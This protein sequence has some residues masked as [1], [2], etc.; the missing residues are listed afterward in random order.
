MSE[1]I[2]SPESAEVR[3]PVLMVCLLVGLAALPDAIIPL[4][5]KAGVMDRWVGVSGLCA[6]VCGSIIGGGV[7]G[8]NEKEQSE[9]NDGRR[10]H[11][12]ILVV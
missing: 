3:H 1:H 5:L 9:A 4:A 8:G 6:L 7:R 12:L 11:A 2:S 10:I